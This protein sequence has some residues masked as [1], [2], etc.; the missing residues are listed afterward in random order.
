MFIF[1][2]YMITY[3]SHNSNK[4]LIIKQLSF[5]SFKFSFLKFPTD[6]IHIIYVYIVQFCGHSHKDQSLARSRQHLTTGFTKIISGLRSVSTL[7]QLLINTFIF[8]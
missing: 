4:L 5:S 6:Y 2:G 3:N 7:D 8:I 1:Y